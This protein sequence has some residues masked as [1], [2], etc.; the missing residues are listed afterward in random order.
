[1][2]NSTTTRKSFFAVMAI[3]LFVLS[4]CSRIV[5][6]P[7]GKGNTAKYICS[8]LFNSNLDF[9]LVRDEFV[10]PDMEPLPFFWRIEVDYDEQL[11]TVGDIFFGTKIGAAVAIYREGI[12]CTLLA[13]RTIAEVDAQ[14]F[15]PLEPPVLPEDQPWPQGS[16]GLHPDVIPGLD[17]VSLDKAISSAFVGPDS[18]GRNTTSVVV[19]YDGKLIAEQY[20]LGVTEDTPVI[21]WS[22]TKSVTST[23]IGIAQDQSLIDIDD[24]A[25][26][27]GWEGTVKELILTKHILHMAAGLVFAEDTSGQSELTQML[28]LEPD[29]AAYTASRTLINTP[30]EVFSYS[31][32]QANLLAKIVQDAAGG[33]LQDAYDF[34]QTQLFHKIDIGS[35]FIEFDSSGHFIGGTY[36]FMTPRDWARLGQLYIQDGNWFGE[37]VVSSEWIEFALTP[38]LVAKEYGAQIW[39]NTDGVKWPD[40]P[41]DVYYFN[42]FHGQEV[43]IVPSHKLVVVRTGVDVV[44]SANAYHEAYMIGILDSLPDLD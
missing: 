35:A 32:G 25:P 1:M 14:A 23:L 7:V 19:V 38:S 26:I 11:V 2:P 31:S 29:Q 27:D 44:G 34:Y 24:P 8:A 16:A 10:A 20:A 18:E 21:G 42:G 40:L 30:G 39:L 12:G 4:G 22:M 3:T 6:L 15:E 17:R 9:E 41:E 33:S 36:G 13:G 28:F 5:D 37:Q 43:F